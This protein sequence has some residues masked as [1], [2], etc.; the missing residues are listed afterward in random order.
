MP[1]VDVLIPVYNAAQTLVEAIKTIQDQ[2]VRDIRI[3]IIDDGST[4]E[5][6]S[7]ITQIAANDSRVLAL[8]K[9]NSG[10]VDA[11]NLGLSQC[12]AQLIARH[13]ADDLADPDRFARQLEYLQANPDCVAVS[14]SARHIDSTGV[15]LG[16]LAKFWPPDTANLFAIPSREPYLL[17]PFLMARR[18]SILAI[19]G[20]RY[21]HHAEDTDLYWRLQ[22]IGRLHNLEEVLGAYRYSSQS[23]TSRS[24]L[25][26][27][28][29]AVYSQLAAI[30]A[31]RRRSGRPDVEF[32]R[33][34][35]AAMQADGSCS[36]IFGLASQSL[37]LTE[38]AYLKAAFA[39]K[40]LELT[41]YRPYELDA[42]DCRFI[43]EALKPLDPSSAEV[44]HINIRRWR[45]IAI[46][47]LVRQGH[48]RRAFILLNRRILL[49]SV[50]RVAGQIVAKATP[51]PLKRRIRKLRVTRMMKS[52]G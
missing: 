49:Q 34:M 19:G 16:T 50:W 41:S 26:G 45:A 15:P 7:L 12:T 1:A 43:V 20:Y 17:H 46:A 3:I 4:D 40:L 8:E 35:T 23:I 31:Q 13:D 52:A 38:A 25:D 14:C 30:S 28:I 10:I 33:R 27:R 39:A 32:N 29:S 5:S 22:E 36:G 24:I 47:R 18:A 44:D 51:R 42:A 6:R 37:D 9:S 2:T 21:I 11:L 48:W